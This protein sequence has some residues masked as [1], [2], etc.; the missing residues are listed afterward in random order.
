MWKQDVSD[1]VEKKKKKN[2]KARWSCE[3]VKNINL[4]RKRPWLLG[5]SVP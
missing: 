3:E 1:I 5:P 4:Q 2:Y